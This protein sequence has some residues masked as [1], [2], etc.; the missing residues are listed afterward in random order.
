MENEVKSKWT[1][2][3]EVR[4]QRNRLYRYA[5]CFSYR[6]VLN[7]IME[8]PLPSVWRLTSKFFD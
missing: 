7:D 3:V 5:A 8:K 4:R 6:N 2:S 1:R